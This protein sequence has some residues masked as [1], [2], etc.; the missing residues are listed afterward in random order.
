MSR[1]NRALLAL[2]LVASIL[3]GASLAFAQQAPAAPAS[4]TKWVDT[5]RGEAE[6]QYVMDKPIVRKDG[7]IV[8]HFQ[9][10][11]M[12]PKAIARLEIQEF[13]YD[14]AGNPVSGDKKFIKRPLMPGEIGE[15]T[16]ETPK[17]PNMDRNSFKFTHANG[18]V[19]PKKVAKFDVPGEAAPAAKAAPKKK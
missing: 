11:N 9:L 17:Q 15:I 16:L 19:K 1:P 10:K 12:M 6:V 14:K 2:A 8:T 4:T 7:T 3:A 5:V 13:W 18:T